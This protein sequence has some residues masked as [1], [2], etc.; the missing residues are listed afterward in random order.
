M[1]VCPSRCAQQRYGLTA[2]SSLISSPQLALLSSSPL[3]CFRLPLSFQHAALEFAGWNDRIAALHG[4]NSGQICTTSQEEKG[5]SPSCEGISFTVSRRN[6]IASHLPSVRMRVEKI[7]LEGV[8]LLRSMAACCVHVCA[9]ACAC[10]PCLSLHLFA[11]PQ[12][13]FMHF[14]PKKDVNRGNNDLYRRHHQR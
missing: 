2:P 4:L 12:R 8:S 5:G 14:L 13:L 6:V 11:V 9:C 1:R 10:A 7:R 3:G